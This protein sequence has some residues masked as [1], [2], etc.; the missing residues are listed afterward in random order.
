[1]FV[2]ALVLIFLLRLRFPRNQPIPTVINRR[3]G[4]ATTACFRK[5]EKT[6]KQFHKAS[7]DLDFLLKCNAYNIFPKFLR[8]KLYRK[9]L[10]NTSLY[11]NFQQKLLD[12]EISFK[13]HRIE[14]L[15]TSVNTTKNILKEKLSFVK[16]I[17]NTASN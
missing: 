12:N 15:K 10:H 2:P 5:L 4:R 11:K 13:K 14:I 9:C 17:M 16:A 3:Y 6:T 8:F 1:M 7:L